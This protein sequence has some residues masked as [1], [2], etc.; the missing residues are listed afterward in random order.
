MERH[1]RDSNSF[2]H[3]IIRYYSSMMGIESRI[4][5]NSKRRID[6]FFLDG[7]LN[8][9]R[10]PICTYCEGLNSHKFNNQQ[11]NWTNNE[12]RNRPSLKYTKERPRWNK[13]MIIMMAMADERKKNAKVKLYE[14]SRLS[15][16][17]HTTCSP[18]QATLWAS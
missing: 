2:F 7:R 1:E 17:I 8:Y 15:D 12:K 9:E 11:W 3:R 5:L 6:F 13:S 10:D 16:L 18:I 14:S 4:I